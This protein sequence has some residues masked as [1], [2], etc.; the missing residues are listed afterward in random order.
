MQHFVLIHFAILIACE[1]MVETLVGGLFL[2]FT[3]AEL[4]L[5][6]PCFSSHYLGV[7][8]IEHIELASVLL[9]FVGFVQDK[10]PF[11]ITPFLLAR[12]FQSVKQ[13]LKG[14]LEHGFQLAPECK[15]LS[16]HL[17]KA[18]FTDAS[19]KVGSVLL[20]GITL[21]L[22]ALLACLDMG[23]CHVRIIGG[24]AVLALGFMFLAFLLAE[25]VHLGIVH[26]LR[27][28]VNAVSYLV[29]RHAV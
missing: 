11:L 4:R 18:F 10:R 6:K 28:A 22:L 29:F 26:L 9:A 1:F 7:G 16:T 12:D 24:I 17:L 5:T 27:N 23:L 3:I 25:S 20:R 14:F 13:L 8:C 21:E 15:F 2:T 19:C